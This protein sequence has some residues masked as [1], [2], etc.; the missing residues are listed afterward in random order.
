M[1]K[2]Y[3]INMFMCKN[4][5]LQRQQNNY[6]MRVIRNVPQ[7]ILVPATFSYDLFIKNEKHFGTR[8]S[9]TYVLEY[10]TVAR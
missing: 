2:L 1:S 7:A 8:I 6:K 9:N 3:I 5:M 10:P 4:S